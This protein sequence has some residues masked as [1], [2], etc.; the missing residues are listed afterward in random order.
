[1]KYH[2]TTAIVNA[3]IITIVLNLFQEVYKIFDGA[4]FA[5]KGHHFANLFIYSLFFFS[6]MATFI[7]YKVKNYRKHFYY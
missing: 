6:W 5:K 7:I 2:V 3:I 4:Y 1:M